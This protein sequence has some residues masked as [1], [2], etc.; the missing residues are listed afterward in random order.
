MSKISIATGADHGGFKMKQEL[1][2]HLKQFKFEVIDFGTNDTK[3]VD[4]PD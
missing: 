3:P 4:Y 1:I 2:K